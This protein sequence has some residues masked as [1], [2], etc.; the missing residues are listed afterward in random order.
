[1]PVFKT[2]LEEKLQ[3]KIDVHIATTDVDPLTVV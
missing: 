3:G 1:M 2:K